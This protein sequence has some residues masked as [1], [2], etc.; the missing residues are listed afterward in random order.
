MAASDRRTALVTGG[1]AGIGLATAHGL[2]SRGHEVIVVG[3][4]SDRGTRAARDI[5]RAAAVPADFMSADLSTVSEVGRLADRILRRIPANL[6]VVV[7]NVGGLYPERHLTTDGIE[8]TLATNVVAPLA[9]TRAL[10]PALSA[11]SP[12]RVVFVNS[13]AHRFRQADLDDLNADRFHRGFD[14]YARAKLVQ[15]LVARTLSRELDPSQVTIVAVNPGP[16]WT[17]QVAAMTPAM[18][19]PRMRLM[20]PLIR[21]VQRSRSPEQAAR[22]VVHAATDPLLTGTTGIWIDQR[23]NVGEPSDTARDD[24]LAA[25]VAARVDA[26]VAHATRHH[27]QTRIRDV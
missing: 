10:L 25:N 18:M 16:A 7:H 26:L 17:G 11:A 19:P 8:A 24:Q 4:N 20:W 5:S 1:T 3:R 2:A 22:A 23:G 21:L 13:D 15:L 27:G 6:D 9:L 14:S 12:S